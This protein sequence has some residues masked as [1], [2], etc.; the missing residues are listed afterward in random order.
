M[1][2]SEFLDED[3]DTEAEE[4][5]ASFPLIPAGRYEAQIVSATVGPTKNGK[6]R[7][8]VLNWSIVSGEYEHRCVWQ[9][10]LIN[11]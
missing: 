1:P 3:F 7:A 5:S 9:N 8:V 6:G 11:H 4:C 2:S 10:I